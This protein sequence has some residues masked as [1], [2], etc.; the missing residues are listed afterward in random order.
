MRL[1]EGIGK[2]N[3]GIV[4]PIKASLKFGNSGVWYLII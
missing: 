2:T 4:N 1:G 3:Q